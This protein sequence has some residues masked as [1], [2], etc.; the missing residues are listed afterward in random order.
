MQRIVCEGKLTT[1]VPGFPTRG[2]QN[3]QEEEL[4]LVHDW[5]QDKKKETEMLEPLQQIRL[6]NSSFYKGNHTHHT[7]L[8]SKQERNRCDPR[9]SQEQHA[10][11]WVNQNCS[12][13]R[14][15][16]S[17]LHYCCNMPRA[18]GLLQQIFYA[19]KSVKHHLNSA[20]NL[21][22]LQM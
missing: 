18:S 2:F 13:L 12:N 19:Q 10:K 6:K 5:L 15:Q 22:T 17:Y 1:L 21:P 16:E 7:T 20:N 11:S 4:K 8:N 3:I 9:N 14:E